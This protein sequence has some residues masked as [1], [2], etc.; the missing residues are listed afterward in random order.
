[1]KISFFI[2]LIFV[3]FICGCNKAPKIQPQEINLSVP[4]DTI[5]F[6]IIGDYGKAGEA[7][8]AVAA[9]VKSWEPDFI[10]TTGDNNYEYGEINT[11]HQNIGA[12]YGD[13]IYNF[14]AP[15][16]LQYQG[17]AFEEKQNRFFPCPGNHDANNSHGLQPYLSYFSLPG[18]ETYYKFTWGPVTF[19]SLNSTATFLEHQKQWLF[20]ALDSSDNTFHV[21]YFHHPP[22]SPGPHG[23][24]ENMQW[25]FSSHKVDC[26]IGGHDHIYAHIEKLDQPGIHYLVNGLGGKSLY[27]CDTTYLSPNEFKTFCYDKD[28]G[29]MWA[30]ATPTELVVKFYAISNQ[31]KAIDSLIIKRNL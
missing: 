24:S 6:A 28:Y 3:V 25:E 29:A 11:I 31:A 21:V 23:N 16:M 18:N 26:V 4:A 9:M 5:T 1:M 27:S 7:E 30:K 14:D 15:E 13:F 17:R 22:Y 10:I 12:Y 20:D 19:F 2:F 8:K